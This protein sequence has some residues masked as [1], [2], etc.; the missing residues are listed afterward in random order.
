MAIAYEQMH[1]TEHDP[2]LEQQTVEYFRLVL[3]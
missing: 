1:E 2:S 3:K